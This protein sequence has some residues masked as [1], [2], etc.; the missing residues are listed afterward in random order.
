[1]G[2]YA[3]AVVCGGNGVW[4]HSDG[5]GGLP[6]GAGGGAPAARRPRAPGTS[7]KALIKGRANRE[8]A[9][10]VGIGWGTQSENSR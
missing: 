2:V 6:G 3:S 5:V 9:R 7:H 8:S 10:P 1:M 4:R